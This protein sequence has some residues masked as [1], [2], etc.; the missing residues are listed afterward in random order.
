MGS[1]MAA[2]RMDGAEPGGMQA[3]GMGAIDDILEA[4][5]HDD[6][7]VRCKKTLLN[8]KQKLFSRGGRKEFCQKGEISLLFGKTLN[9]DMERFSREK[10]LF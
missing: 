2:Y 3:H 1:D 9:A 6:D 4:S 8:S 10:S 5:H 7:D